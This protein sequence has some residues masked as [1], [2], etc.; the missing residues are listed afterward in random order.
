MNGS[1]PMSVALALCAN[2]AADSASHPFTVHDMLAMQRISEPRVSP[3]GKRVVF[4]V[5]TTD[6]EE[7]K[8]RTS[9]W[10]VQTNGGGLRRLT[11]AQAN[12]NDP[13]WSPD[14]MT[15]FFFLLDR[16][17]RRCGGFPLTAAKPSN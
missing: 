12:D 11:A 1:L 9:L 17:R 6:M 16:E 5:R 15:I 14:G 3:D 4:V 10:L 13:C 7:N 2:P 8:G